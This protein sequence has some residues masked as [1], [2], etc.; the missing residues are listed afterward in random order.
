MCVKCLSHNRVWSHKTNVVV[1]DSTWDISW[2]ETTHKKSALPLCCI[3]RSSHCLE[4]FFFLN[5]KAPRF[6]GLSKL[7]VCSTLEGMTPSDL[8]SFLLSIPRS[9][10]VWLEK[11]ETSSWAGSMWILFILRVPQFPPVLAGCV[12]PGQ[13]PYPRALSLCCPQGSLSQSSF[14]HRYK[15]CAPTRSF[16]QQ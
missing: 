13:H 14:A 9:S 4:F 1:A 7:P 16:F 6:P 11:L 5:F 12:V 2:F 8:P 3:A 10:L 15:L